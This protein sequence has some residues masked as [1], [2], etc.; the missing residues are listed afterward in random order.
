MD[1][2]IIIDSI[3]ITGA[4]LIAIFLIISSMTNPNLFNN[5]NYD[6]MLNELII[7]IVSIISYTVGKNVKKNQ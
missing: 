5:P 1:S 2:S 4:I 3:A 6:N 7:G